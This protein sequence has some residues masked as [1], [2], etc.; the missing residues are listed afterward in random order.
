[1]SRPNLFPHSRTLNAHA[2]ARA[3]T[4]THTHTRANTHTQTHTRIH[5]STTAHRL[6]TPYDPK[7][8]CKYPTY[9]EMDPVTRGDAEQLLAS[10]VRTTVRDPDLSA[11][12]RDSPTTLGDQKQPQ[13]MKYNERSLYMTPGTRNLVLLLR[14]EKG[15]LSV[16]TCTLPEVAVVPGPDH[17]LFSC[18]PGVGDAFM[19]L[20]EVGVALVSCVTIVCHA[21]S[22]ACA[23]LH[24]LRRCTLPCPSRLRH[25]CAHAHMTVIICAFGTLVDFCELQIVADYSNASDP[26]VC[27]WTD[28][29]LS[30]LPDSGSRTCAA[31]LPNGAGVRAP[32]IV[33]VF[34]CCCGGVSARSMRACGCLCTCT[35]VFVVLG[36]TVGLC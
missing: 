7:P 19:N 23:M 14:G 9:L 34:V 30:T 20:V 3:H 2:R 24:A 6:C 11:R 18:R 35:R 5:A 27:D 26:R 29:V 8:E 10:F 1:M 15:G 28:P 16:S 21:S 12:R 13:T 17:T 4:H 22:L 36:C 32:R 25:L 33:F 31:R